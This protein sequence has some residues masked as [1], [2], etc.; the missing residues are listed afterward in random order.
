MDKYFVTGGSGFL[1]SYVI[2]NLSKKGIDFINYDKIK[3]NK[4]S[5][6]FIEGDI[7]DYEKIK[8]SLKGCN[9][10]IHSA[11][12]LPL[13]KK[14]FRSINVSGT[15]NL[16]KAA[17]LNNISH[18]TFISSSSIFGTKNKEIISEDSKP[19]PVEAY[20]RSK[21]D[22]EKVIEEQLNKDISRN[23]IRSRTIVGKN[24][25]G[26][27]DM[28]FNFSSNGVPVFLIGNGKNTI[29]LI[30][31]EEISEVIVRLTNKNISGYFNL[32]NNDNTNIGKTFE[33]FI[34]NIGSNSKIVKLPVL[35]SVSI[36]FLLDVMKLS[37]FGPWH[38][39]SFHKSCFF[40]SSKAYDLIGFTPKKNNE[41]ILLDSF[42][43][44]TLNTD[45]LVKSSSTHKNKLDLKIFKV[46]N[47]IF[48]RS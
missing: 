46:L 39:K 33:N 44:Y 27:F 29:Q 30:D 41:K 47:F 11:A 40:E 37:P 23:F 13:N 36:L 12:S 5:E 28:L 42:K 18:F 3:P 31:V 4:Y 19:K 43:H 35:P 48:G 15:K 32:G 24:R 9:K 17:N 7:R 22:A 25:L 8:L 16:V 21:Y 26:I 10:I 20:G 1:G 38:Y 45:S 6:N 2:E 14:D 34:D